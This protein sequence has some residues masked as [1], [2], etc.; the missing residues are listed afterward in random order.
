MS[1]SSDEISSLIKRRIKEFDVP[2]LAADVGIVTEVGDGIA[3]IYGLQGAQALELLEFKGGIS[4][5]ALNLEE[6][7]V[8]A[9]I[10]GPYEGIKEGDEVRT[11]GKIIQVPVGEALVGRVVNAL[12]E[13]I[14]GKGPIETKEFAPVEKVAPGVITR[15]PVDTP[16][17]TGIKAI[18]AMIPIGRGQREL[19]IGD[20][21]TG[22]TAIALDTIINQRANWESGDPARQ[23]K[24]VYVA[25]GQKG[26]TTAQVKQALEDAGAMEYTAIVAAPASDPAGFKYIAPYTGSAIGQHWMYAGQHVLI[27]FDDLSKQ[28]SEERRVGKE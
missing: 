16:L 12:G 15:Q 24:C 28:R 14:D 8:G 21:Q 26:S 19:I 17:Q 20:R 25:I 13:P 9:V 10:L 6:D 23:V 11:T 7:S 27:I 3:Q 4:G 2:I 18:D 1:I 22:K 5:I